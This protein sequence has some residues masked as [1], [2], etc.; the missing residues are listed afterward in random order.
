MN[1]NYKFKDILKNKSIHVYHGSDVLVKE[2]R[3]MQPVRALDFGTGFYTTININQAKSFAKKVQDRNGSISAHISIY[4]LNVK[5]LKEYNCLFF[6]NPDKKWLNFVSLNRNGIYSEK[7]YDI[8]YGPVANDTIFKTFIAYQNGVLNEKETLKK[9]KI[10]VLFNQLV[11]VNEESL[12]C[13]AFCDE[14]K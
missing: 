1:K 4:N 12:K 3:I 10:N 14:L 13:L 6:D 7:S 11:F 8:I 5:L 2:P 9:L